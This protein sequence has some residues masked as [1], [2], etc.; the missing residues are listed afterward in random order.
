[1]VVAAVRAD[2]IVVVA[3]RRT[4]LGPQSSGSGR[5]LIGPEQ[6]KLDVSADEKWVWA[7]AGHAG[8]PG[9]DLRAGLASISRSVSD[10][11]TAATRT[12][13]YFDQSAAQ[14]RAGVWDPTGAPVPELMT[15]AHV[16]ALIAGVRDGEPDLRLVALTDQGPSQEMALGHGT[17]KVLAP[18]TKE[19]NPLI[20]AEP[21]LSAETLDDAANIIEHVVRE[22]AHAEPDLVSLTLDVAVIDVA[23]G[24]VALRRGPVPRPAPAG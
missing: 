19:L 13:R 2:G 5:P 18:P 6:S 10:T 12:R 17:L 24:A 4:V 22:V 14:I 20:A 11:A 1:M 16:V 7:L 3:D 23:D 9:L 15:R 8:V 21:A